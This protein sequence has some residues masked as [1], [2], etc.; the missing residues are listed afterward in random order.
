MKPKTKI[1][2][3]T[4]GFILPYMALV[5]Y[6]ALRVHEHPLPTWFLYFGLSYIFATMIVVALFGRKVQ[7]GTRPETPEKSKSAWLWLGKAWM[8]Y[9]VVAWS[10]LFLWGAY[11]TFDGSLQWRRSVPAGMFLLAFIALFSWG[12]Y[13]DFKGQAKS[14]KTASEKDT[15]GT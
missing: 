5:M 4:F 10:V 13:K 12:L 3:L 15:S 14:P 9:L 1:L 8:A 2:A 7:G 11:L 6:F